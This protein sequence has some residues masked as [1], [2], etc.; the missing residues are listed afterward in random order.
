MLR[1]AMFKRFVALIA[2]SICFGLFPIYDLSAQEVDVVEKIEVD[3]ITCWLR[4]SKDAIRVGEE[5]DLILTCR[6]IETYEEKV[7]PI[8]SALDSRAMTLAPFEVLSGERYPDVYDNYRRFFQ[9][10][11]VAR[12]ISGDYFGQD[13]KV[14]SIEIRYFIRQQVTERETMDS[15]EYVYAMPEYP[16]RILSLVPID[17]NDIRDNSNIT[18]DTARTHSLRS[19]ILY[20]VSVIFFVAAGA[21]IVLFVRQGVIY[22][23]GDR[24]QKVKAL[25]DWRILM[26][27]TRE[28]RKVRAQVQSKRWNNELVGK[29]LAIS[30][31]AM[32]IAVYQ[33]V[34][35][36][37]VSMGSKD[38]EGQLKL[39]KGLLWRRKKVLVSSSLT[40]EDLEV[41]SSYFYEHGVNKKYSM[42]INGLRDIFIQ[43]NS[44]RYSKGFDLDNTKENLDESLRLCIFYVTKLKFYNISGV[45]GFFVL[46]RAWWKK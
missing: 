10:N 45:H 32:T 25:S 23:R 17:A 38:L 24:P 5:F 8:F 41:I 20:Y 2:L 35:Q 40:P 3:P 26:G 7:V 18:L 19:N 12:L 4:T 33:N 28:I 14:P 22:Y 11:Y 44:S 36:R 29:F 1:W 34:I 21:F 42:L 15:Q 9:F 30:R 31:V 39:G 37:V 13:A 43:L 6:I 27:L 16:V 46:W